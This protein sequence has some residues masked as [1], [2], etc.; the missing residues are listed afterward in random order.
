[1]LA[2]AAPSHVVTVGLPTRTAPKDP[3]F[4]FRFLAGDAVAAVL[5]YV[6]RVAL[7][8][9]PTGQG[10]RFRRVVRLDVG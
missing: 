10:L 6:A 7:L 4:G 1:M 2:A 3:M 9:Y 5:T 8:Y